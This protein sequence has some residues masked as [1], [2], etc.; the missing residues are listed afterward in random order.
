MTP[1]PKAEW[2]RA[3]WLQ[4]EWLQADGQGGFA[5]GT[6]GG[7]R[8]RRYHALLLAPLRPPTSRVVLV[9]GVE[10]LVTLGGS[11]VALST[12]HYAPDVTHPRGIDALVA[13]AHGPW[14]R[15][16][17][18][19]PDGATLVHECL[20][21]PVDG[22]VVLSWQ[23]DD[24]KHRPA[25]LSVSPLLSGRDHHALMRENPAFA[26]A[27]RAVAGNATW[28]PYVD[29]PA[30]AALSNGH[31]RHE[32]QWFRNF[33][34]SEEAARGLDAGE[35]LAAPG[36][37]DF[38]LRSGEAVM[39]L[40]A[41][42]HIAIDARALATR[43]RGIEAARRQP[44]DALQLAAEAYFVRRAPGHTVIA[45]YPWFTD[46]GRDTFIAMRGLLLARGR[47]DIAA[48]ILG[49]WAGHLSEGML[50]NRFVDGG[51][52]PEYN[53]VDASL[54]FV[55]V[56]HELLA[57]T[58]VAPGLRERLMQAVHTIV[59]AYR[60]GTRHGIRMDHD[61]LLACGEPGLQLTWMDAK[62][63]DRVITPRIG[64]PVEVQ[65]LWINALV[66]AGQTDLAE[67]ARQSFAERFWNPQGHCL[68]DVVDA[69]HERGK[70]DA[71]VRPNQIFAVGGLPVALLDGER[72]ATV[73]ATVQA[74]LLTPMGLRS[75]APTD[76]A[77]CGQYGG[78]YGGG[79]AERDGA[80]HQGTV[81]PWLIGAF[82]D[83][84]LNV[85]GDNP[86]QRAAVRALCL[87][88]LLAHLQSAGLG[89][90]SEIADGDAPHTPRGCPFQAWSLG[91]LLRAMARAAAGEDDP[92]LV[93]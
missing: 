56:V 91:E 31:Y 65:A 59:G 41:G 85:R 42:G 30:I 4:A 74:Q 33:H 77:Y 48:S 2:L 80:Y 1:A 9:N 14:P 21:D 61:A 44:L 69:D 29:L 72:A 47:F 83:A 10:A 87:E 18:G 39:V 54:W 3:E 82:V 50:P 52:A 92:R 11:A 53:A 5:S 19:L 70:L 93:F 37:F 8:T 12:Q 28:R 25:T 20:V 88:P 55:I 58:T 75:L 43:V 51:E 89:H 7:F 15:W 73:L 71:S 57:A 84:W 6:V 40:R 13:F 81:W 36:C 49:A 78:H 46:W 27:A 38:D 62:V 63:G 67:Q 16:T 66:C 34:Y 26:F 90:V 86:A 76:A 79:P 32:P 45:G 64:K 17:F 24:A 60:C 22:S 68:Y 23:L 35:D